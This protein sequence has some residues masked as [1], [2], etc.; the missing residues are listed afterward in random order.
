MK[1]LA[2]A[3]TLVEQVREAIVAEIASGALAP[4]ARVI[5]E[6]IAAGLG[7]SRQPVQQALLLLRK[8]G[9]LHDAPG[10]G[11]IVA[12]LDVE[13]SR[14]MYEIRAVM[15][16]LAARNAAQRHAADAAAEGPALVEAGRKAVRSGHIPALIA[17]DM[18]FHALLYRLSANPLIPEAMAPQWAWTKRVMG[19]VMLHDERPRDIW[20]QHAAILDAVVAG[21]AARAERL[22]R[23]HVTQAGDYM[24]E[25]L[26]APRAGPCPARPPRGSSKLGTTRRLLESPGGA[27]AREGGTGDQRAARRVP[28]AAS[29]AAT[30]HS[31]PRS[32]RR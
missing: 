11:L 22:A 9:L 4:G 1:A 18:A 13:Q 20:H 16:G 6:L 27:T 15:E 32:S 24:L 19:E 5:Q 8:Q 12:P 29:A 2:P 10:R 25:R 28:A 31:T 30:R 26:S 21:D 7:V 23:Q 17:A 3:P 14:H